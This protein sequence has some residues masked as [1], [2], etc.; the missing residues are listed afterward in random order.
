[1]DSQSNSALNEEN[2]VECSHKTT[3]THSHL[4]VQTP[5]QAFFDPTV[6]TNTP[7]S[8]ASARPIES[9]QSLHP[10]QCPSQ[11]PQPGNPFLY[12]FPQWQPFLPPP[13]PTRKQPK[14]NPEIPVIQ[15]R[16]LT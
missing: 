9:G 14:L 8:P 2:S 5:A 16:E 7:L 15:Q 1:M 6:Q 4:S 3:H 13:P 10:K 12:L 11:P